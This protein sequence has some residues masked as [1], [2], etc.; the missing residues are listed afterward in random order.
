MTTIDQCL[1]KQPLVWIE[2]PVSGWK[3]RQDAAR[4]EAEIGEGKPPYVIRVRVTKGKTFFIVSRGA[5]HHATVRSLDRAKAIAQA[6]Y[7]QK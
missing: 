1:V 4:Y 6:N 3:Y 2:K 7:D 5:G